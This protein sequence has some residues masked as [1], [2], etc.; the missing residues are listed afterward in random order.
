MKKVSV[1]LKEEMAKS[2][3]FTRENWGLALGEDFPEI[4]KDLLADSKLAEKLAGTWLVDRLRGS[5]VLDKLTDLGPV[6]SVRKHPEI[7]KPYFEFLY[8][9]IQIGRKMEREQAEALASIARQGG[10]L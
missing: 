1:A 7:L 2:E 9:G 4:A 8:W 6:E 3:A 5:S 10:A